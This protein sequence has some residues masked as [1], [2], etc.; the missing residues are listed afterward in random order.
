MANAQEI[1][2]DLQAALE[3]FAAVADA[4]QLAKTER[5]GQDIVVEY[6]HDAAGVVANRGEAAHVLT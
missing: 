1:V 5:E 4:L 3:E 2:E 6:G